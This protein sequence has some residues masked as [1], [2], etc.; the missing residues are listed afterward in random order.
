MF[1]DLRKSKENA[2]WPLSPHVTE[3]GSG[4]VVGF[5]TRS[6]GLFVLLALLFSISTAWACETPVY[7]YA[8]YRWQPTPYEVYSFHDDS[9]ATAHTAVEKAIAEVSEGTD[10][11]AN[12]VFIP[13]NVAKDPE[14]NSVTP[15]IKQAWTSQKEQTLPS[16]LI[17]T[18]YGAQIY[19][20]KLDV[21]AI[22]SLVDSPARKQMAQQLEAGKIGV[23]LFLSGKDKQQNEQT[24]QILTG[25]VKEVAEG[26]ISLY[27]APSANA[28]DAAADDSVAESNPGLEL[29]LIE[30]NR[31]DE[32]EAWLVRSLLAMES[33]LPDESRPMVFLTYGR[34]RA[35]L[36]YIGEGITREN[37]IHEVEFI[38][39]AC[40]CTVKE[41]NPGVDLLVRYDWDAASA[42]LADRFGTEEGNESQFGPSDFLP[43]LI[44]PSSSAPPLAAADDASEDAPAEATVAAVEN[45]NVPSGENTYAAEE[46]SSAGSE[47]ANE[48][49]SATENGDFAGATL[50]VDA[51]SATEST[52]PSG[53]SEAPVAST[54]APAK[55]HAEGSSDASVNEETRQVASVTPTGSTDASHAPVFQ[56]QRTYFSMLVV[57]GGLAIGL[58]IL[59]GLTFFVMRPH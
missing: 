57:G 27:T 22:K 53:D 3:N 58:A 18:P 35:L 28:A 56:S 30:V 45:P 13:V 44:I 37:L 36:P 24:K 48:T 8:M 20:G 43:Q 59:F 47:P 34:G 23:L 32:K 52:V 17:S 11:R 14:L 40:S 4:R 55:A 50:L 42:A 38:S 16:Y 33:D 39:G 5:R 15:D 7:R 46:Q 1:V 51:G 25:L 54:E 26:K 31:D 9:N 12:V 41:Q 29:G 19:S 21:E 10:S 6:S 2:M 49:D